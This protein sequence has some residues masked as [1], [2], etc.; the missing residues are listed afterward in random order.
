MAAWRYEMSPLVLKKYFTHSLRSLMKYFSTLEE[1]FRISVRPCNILCFFHL[2]LIKVL[3][4][5]FG[6]PLIQLLH[7][8]TDAKHTKLLLLLDSS[9]NVHVFPRT[10]EAK[11]IV[12]KAASSIFFFLAD[13][14]KGDIRG[15]MLLSDAGKSGFHVREMWNVNIPR[16]SQVISNIG[17][18]RATS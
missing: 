6:E 7:Y 11:E 4:D 8:F 13:K 2:L 17:N 12:S 5:C 18:N 15:Y 3:W 14:E 16:A 9:L 1:K 10:S